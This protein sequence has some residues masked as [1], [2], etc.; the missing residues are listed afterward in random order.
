MFSPEDILMLK[1]GPLLRRRFID[2]GLSQA[3]SSYFYDLQQYK[4]IL[5]N[6]NALLREIKVSQ[7]N[8][9]T[10]FVWDNSLAK[11][12]SKIMFLRQQFLN[13]L[14]EIIKPKHFYLTERN[15]DVSIKYKPSFKIEANIDLDNLESVF[16]QKLTEKQK[17]DSIRAFTSIGPHRDDFEILVNNVSIRNFGSQGQQRTAILSLKLAEVVLMNEMTGEN[18]VLLLDDFASELDKKRQNLLLKSIEGVQVIITSTA[19]EILF[20][21]NILNIKYFNI[22]NGFCI[23]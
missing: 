5:N 14:E 20:D 22:K 3:R 17:D 1:E 12:G 21:D 11:I 19:K 8:K 4:K 2:I 6:R 10:L 13:R 15:E 9:D 7:K 18:P 16:L 23:Q